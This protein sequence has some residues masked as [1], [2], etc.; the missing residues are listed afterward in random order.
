MGA[1]VLM[2]FNFQNYFGITFKKVR[3]VAYVAFHPKNL[4]SLLAQGDVHPTLVPGVFDAIPAGFH[5]I[6]PGNNVRI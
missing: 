4:Q 1:D 6:N 3:F 2:L 5:Q